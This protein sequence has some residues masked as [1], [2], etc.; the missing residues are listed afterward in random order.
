MASVEF[1]LELALVS[2]MQFR[3]SNLTGRHVAA[4][5]MIKPKI[6]ESRLLPLA[7]VDLPSYLCF[8]SVM[9]AKTNKQTN[10]QHSGPPVMC[11]NP[12]LAPQEKYKADF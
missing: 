7:S 4:C 6:R 1:P 5:V 12:T 10:K 9:L 8:A 11:W 2:I 3:S